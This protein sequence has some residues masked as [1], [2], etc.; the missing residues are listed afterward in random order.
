MR[1]GT[2]LGIVVVGVVAAGFARERFADKAADKPAAIPPAA[3]G[4]PQ[5]APRPIK[6]NVVA[7]QTGDAA[8]NAAKQKAKSTLP[9]FRELVARR[10][11]GTYTVKFPLT[12]NGAT[13]HIWLQ[14]TGDRG[15]EF[16]GLIANDPVNGA[17]YRKGQPMTVPASV[18]EDWMVKNGSEIYGGYT[19]RVAIADMPKDQQTKYRAMFRD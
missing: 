8:M 10:T 6:Q 4:K 18:V 11:P 14:L 7:Y 2:L 13:E 15:V 19:A 5:S 12:Q 1:F 3:A 17:K 9:R 16:V